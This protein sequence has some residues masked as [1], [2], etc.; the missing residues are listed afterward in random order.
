MPES[1]SVYLSVVIPAYNEGEKITKDLEAAYSYLKRKK[2]DGEIIVVD[3]G[4][5]DKTCDI[6]KSKQKEIPCLKLV[7]SDKNYGKGHALRDGIAA[8]IGEYVVFADAGLCVPYK[9]IDFGLMILELGEAD[10]AHGSR[11]YG[12][13]TA[14]V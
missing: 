6:V 2:I 12:N 3:D 5:A 9:Y 10:I 7:T 4:S 14:K 8:S 13:S 1:K 11:K